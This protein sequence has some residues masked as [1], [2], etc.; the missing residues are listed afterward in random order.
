MPHE[1]KAPRHASLGLSRMETLSYRIIRRREETSHLFR[2]AA[3][4]SASGRVRRGPPAAL[5]KTVR[6]QAGMVSPQAAHQKQAERGD[7]GACPPL[8]PT[9]SSEPRQG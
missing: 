8:P 3:L 2:T 5:R 6:V 1:P 9:F 4:E 7:L